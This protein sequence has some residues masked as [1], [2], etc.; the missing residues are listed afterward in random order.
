MQTAHNTKIKDYRSAYS[1]PITPLAFE[2]TGGMHAK[3]IEHLYEM[4]EELP[5]ELRSER[6]HKVKGQIAAI[7]A[8]GLVQAH[9]DYRMRV[10]RT[11]N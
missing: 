7:L 3:T 1:D 9:A 5:S 10:W 6:L 8:T 11:R 2:T 4:T